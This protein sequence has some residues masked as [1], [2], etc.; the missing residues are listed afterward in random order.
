MSYY[1]DKKMQ[2]YRTNIQQNNQNYSITIYYAGDEKLHISIK[3]SNNNSE[4]IIEYSNFY[5][6]HQLH[7]INKYFRNFDNLEQI[8]RDLDKLLKNN[9]ISIEEKNGFIILSIGVL[10]KKEPTNIIFKLIKKQ[11]TDFL[12]NKS[13]LKNP[14]GLNNN[15]YNIDRNKTTLSMPKYNINEANELKSI[16]N[17]LN[18]RV[19]MLESSR[20]YDS[21]T[22]DN[23]N[24]KILNNNNNI[25]DNKLVI[26]NLNTIIN[27]INK[28]EDL[29][30]EK[31]NK[32][33]DLEDRIN[34]YE[35][36]INNT[37]SYP[38]C[39]FPNKS[40]RSRNDNNMMNYFKKKRNN[41][42]NDVEYEIEMNSGFMNENNIYKSRD[43]TDPNLRNK[44]NKNAKYKQQ[45]RFKEI[46]ES[47]DNSNTNLRT[48][49]N[50]LKDS[51]KDNNSKLSKSI[52]SKS[53]AN[54]RKNRASNSSNI[55][56][57]E[58]NDDFG[59]KR[60]SMN[61]QNKESKKD[62]SSEEKKKGKK[63]KK[64]RKKEV[65]KG[66]ESDES[67]ANSE[68][69]EMKK[70]K[71]R[72]SNNSNTST[73]KND[74]RKNKRNNSVTSE[75][76]NIQKNIDEDINE[77]KR[78][79]KKTINGLSI[80]ER[81]DLK[82]YIN[83]RIFFTKEELQMVKKKITNKKKNCHTYFEVL[84][85]ASIDGDYENTII[86]C[87]EGIYPQLILFYS[88][89]GARFGVFINKEMS[90]NIFGGISYKEVPGTSFLI[91]LNSL[92]TYDILN[93]KK[94]TNDHPEKLCFGRTFY[95]NNNGSNWL[96]FTQRN[97]FLG[98]KCMI[99]D[100]ESSFGNI[101]TNEIVGSKKEY[102]LK[103][104][105]IFK[106]VIYSGNENEEEEEDNKYVR[107]REIK[108]KNFSK[109]HA[110]NNDDDTIKIKNSRI[111]N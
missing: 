47:K 30:Q 72:K 82:N 110:D 10:I 35:E 78:M 68:K 102:I 21:A 16:L 71:R 62:S 108:I 60:N 86:A 100:K 105:E 5:S 93:G 22:K 70:K 45:Y 99:G 20:R 84:Y 83:S 89:E 74:N 109:K 51:Y 11:I 28:L 25:N 76:K 92:K 27:R 37:M 3:Y 106:V 19:S 1:D 31:D 32:I 64:K 90:T 52:K 91:S 96:I 26:G 88:E 80:V 38:T 4:E 42:S 33:K 7:I 18:D 43:K 103:D 29:N 61:S 36:N 56:N 8:C 73:D 79:E 41:N 53:E 58:D 12:P 75:D 94:A 34:K 81:E 95:F 17:D 66:S 24:N 40:Q 54:F 63:R 48:K 55:K 107:E 57:D 69:E 98:T 6:Y 15:N 2:K 101:N 85:R 59:N 97:G 46:E 23:L 50:N 104:V 111:D 14:Y 39:S 44:N 67:D 13:R 87:C 77:K 65:E 9:K 49:K